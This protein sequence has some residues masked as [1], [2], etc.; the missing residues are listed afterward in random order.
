M[1]LQITGNSESAIVIFLLDFLYSKIII[2][3]EDQ[4][5][6]VNADI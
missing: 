5:G 6:M 2:S 3:E 1:D 4:G